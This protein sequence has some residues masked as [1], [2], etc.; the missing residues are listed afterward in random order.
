MSAFP[1]YP[2]HSS[3][4]FQS[5][6]DLADALGGL[7]SVVAQNLVLEINP[8]PGVTI[9]AI[10]TNFPIENNSKVKIPDL[11]GEE[12]RDVLVEVPPPSHL[13]AQLTCF[14]V[15]IGPTDPGDQK[16]ITSS[17]SY[18]CVV[19]SS[20]VTSPAHITILNRPTTVVP[21]QV[22]INVDVDEQRNRFKCADAL[23]AAKKLADAG[24]LAGAR[25]LLEKQLLEVS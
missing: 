25:S 11:Y 17:I 5:N 15:K 13:P 21:E 24:N 2:P 14:Q 8:C 3:T 9:E 7:L 23:T 10:K 20:M 19:S 12:K 6:L 16:L 4:N 18:F 22:Q 1:R